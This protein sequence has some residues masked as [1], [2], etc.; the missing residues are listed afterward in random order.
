M[1]DEVDTIRKQRLAQMQQMQHQQQRADH[2]QQQQQQQ[3]E[4][5]EERRRVILRAVLEPDAAERLNR[6][7]LVKPDKARQVENTI[8]SMAQ[9]G[10]LAGKV[11][12]DAL[13]G[14][15]EKVQETTQK[16]TSGVKWKRDRDFAEDDDDF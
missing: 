9:S 4:E 14:L 11:S 16:N 15:L 8:L 13:I 6:I 12:E 7:A 10:R 1:G 5:A 3:R 2:Q